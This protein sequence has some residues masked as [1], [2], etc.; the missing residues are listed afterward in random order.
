MVSYK[1]ETLVRKFLKLFA[2]ISVNSN[3]PKLTV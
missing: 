3:V 1:L 2:D